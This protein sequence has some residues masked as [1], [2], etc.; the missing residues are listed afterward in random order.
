MY[1]YFIVIRVPRVHQLLMG[2]SI[3]SSGPNA[4]PYYYNWKYTY[5]VYD[6]I[7]HNL[8]RTSSNVL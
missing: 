7:S 8:G 5:G 2:S 3:Y 6:T 4:A 1:V